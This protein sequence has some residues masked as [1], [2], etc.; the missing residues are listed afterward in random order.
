MASEHISFSHVVSV[1]FVFFIENSHLSQ[2]HRET[3]TGPD[4]PLLKRTRKNGPDGTGKT[5]TV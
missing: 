2:S 5:G 1:C 3:K 4:Q